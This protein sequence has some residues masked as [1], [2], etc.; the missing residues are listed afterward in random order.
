[1][2][3]HVR[4]SILVSITLVLSIAACREQETD[5]RIVASGHVEATEVRLSTKVG[6]T[7]LTRTVDEGDPVET[8]LEIARIDTVDLELELATARAE[9]AR[10]AADLALKK[11][12]YRKE[13]IAEAEAMVIQT[14][15]D[16]ESARKD[17]ERMEALLASGSGTTKSR[18]DALARRDVAAARLK[19]AREQLRKLR[20]GFRVEEIDVAAAGLA[21]AEARIAQLEQKIHDA[22]IVSPTTGIVTA[23]IAEPGELLAPGAPIVVVTDLANAWLNVYVGEPSLGKIRLGQPAEVR[24]DGGEVR[25]GRV[26]FIAS[27]AEFTPKNVQT[28]DERV[29]LVFKVKIAL[30]NR[31]GTFKPGMPAEAVLEPAAVGAAE[32]ASG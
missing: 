21:A 28:R 5:G 3:L 26:S 11:T 20:A 7:L 12:G 27:Q 9:R 23:K 16:L 1:M 8:G 31:D 30:D 14:E 4:R 15:A 24:T 2:P 19:A 22:V 18:D 17:L 25:E 29:K 13:E 6:G 10:A 32:A